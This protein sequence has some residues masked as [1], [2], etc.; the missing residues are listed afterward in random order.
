M[1]I[2]TGFTGTA[3][4]DRL[5]DRHVIFDHCRLTDDNA[6]GMIEHD[7]TTNLRRRVNIHLERHGDL[8]LQEDCQRAAAFIP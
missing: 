3:E 1:T 4:G 2:A 5:Q 6:G 7:P 8:V